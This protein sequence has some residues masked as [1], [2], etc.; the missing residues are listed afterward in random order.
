MYFPA[1]YRTFC[2]EIML[3]IMFLF[4][5]I[6]LVNKLLDLETINCGEYSL[7]TLYTVSVCIQTIYFLTSLFVAF[8]DNYY[9]KLQVLHL[10]RIVNPGCQKLKNIPWHNVLRACHLAICNSLISHILSLVLFIPLMHIRGACISLINLS[11]N[12]LIDVF[13]KYP[14]V[15][16][17]VDFL[18]Y[19]SHRLFHLIPYLYQNF[20]KLHHEW[21]HTFGVQAIAC[22][23]LEHICVNLFSVFGALFII[24]LPVELQII[25]LVHAVINTVFS[26]SGYDFIGTLASGITHDYHHHYFKVEYGAGGFADRLFKTTLNDVFPNKIN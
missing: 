8:I 4:F 19:F 11:L 3:F 12:E 26:H 13:M 22:H 24:K 2:I 18:F 6:T 10:K 17:I 20:H 21:Q 16:Y 9:D 15:Y 23:P 1:S 7:K 5:S 25:F 14:F